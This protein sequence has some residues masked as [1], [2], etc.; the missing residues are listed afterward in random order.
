MA[1]EFDVPQLVRLLATTISTHYSLR[2]T[3]KVIKELSA[4]AYGTLLGLDNVR[5]VQ[6]RGAQ[7]YWLISIRI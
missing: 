6:A 2:A 1:S 5:S 3:P 4:S 7:L